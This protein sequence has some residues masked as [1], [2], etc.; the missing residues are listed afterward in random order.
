[1]TTLT[2]FPITLI[3]RNFADNPNDFNNYISEWAGSHVPETVLMVI[4]PIISLTVTA[5]SFGSMFAH[6]ENET[7]PNLIDI[8]YFGDITKL[9]VDN[10]YRVNLEWLFTDS[11]TEVIGAIV[12]VMLAIVGI[13]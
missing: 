10:I 7:Y 4:M 5:F 3:N 6:I 2:Q 8:G 11:L 12:R 1:M 9:H 13:V